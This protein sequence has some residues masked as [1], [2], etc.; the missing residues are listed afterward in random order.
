M[1]NIKI[2]YNKYPFLGPTVWILNVQYFLVQFIVAT[3]WHSPT[4]SWRRNTI[5]DLGSSACGI[6]SGRIVC[7]PWH[8]I[9]N[10]SFL[11]LGLTMTSGSLLIYQEFKQNLGA[12]IGFS[13][14]AI[15]GFGTIIVGLYPEN[16]VPLMHT[17]GAALPFVLGNIGLIFLSINLYKINTG[18]RVYAFISG[19]I[20]LIALAFFVLHHYGFLGSGGVER[21]VAYPQTIWLIVFGI[22]RL[23]SRY[24][25]VRPGYN[26]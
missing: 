15:A 23:I 7:S 1:G 17:L 24:L 12:L 25:N 9:M 11:V 4:Y 10:I 20:A 14:M 6:V 26:K 22:Y 13:L 18:M 8:S 3:A 19:L 21:I 5:S 16:S 2:L